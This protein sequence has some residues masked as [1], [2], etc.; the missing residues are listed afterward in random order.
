MFIVVLIALC[1]YLTVSGQ[2]WIRLYHFM[3]NV[4]P[5][6]NEASCAEVSLGVSLEM[7]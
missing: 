7:G 3:N 5:F 6:I 1:D 2:W 4:H